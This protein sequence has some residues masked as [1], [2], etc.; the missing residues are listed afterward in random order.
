M[1]SIT[2]NIEVQDFLK[3]INNNKEKIKNKHNGLWIKEGILSI[4]HEKYF[5]L[6]EKYDNKE[7]RKVFEN[8][9]IYVEDAI[10]ALHETYTVDKFNLLVKPIVFIDENIFS[11][12][13]NEKFIEENKEQIKYLKKY[14]SYIK[15]ILESSEI[16]KI[17]DFFQSKSKKKLID[18]VNVLINS[19]DFQSKTMLELLDNNNNIQNYVSIG[20]YL[21]DKHI[22]NIHQIEN[23]NKVYQC[24]KNDS[25]FTNKWFPKY[26]EILVPKIKNQE[27][28]EDLLYTLFLGFRN[29][30]KA[31]LNIS[32]DIFLKNENF[33]FSIL[34]FDNQDIYSV[35]YER[36]IFN[37]E[38]LLKTK[39]LDEILKKDITIIL[40][41]LHPSFLEKYYSYPLS[42]DSSE[43][44]DSITNSIIDGY[45]Y[46]DLLQRA[47]KDILHNIDENI[48]NVVNEFI[49]DVKNERDNT[50]T[51]LIFY[52]GQILEKKTPLLKLVVDKN[53]VLNSISNIKTSNV[54]KK[55]L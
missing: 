29:N 2:E 35:G 6:L 39:N 23:F 38:L 46:V 44:L 20:H 16:N 24:I 11:Y 47:K 7:L 17:K 18:A 51:M 32:H 10:F 37:A 43:K 30:S 34:K 21:Y 53:N 45:K 8:L 28:F 31:F 36:A 49:I 27:D 12:K 5:M 22:V 4:L 1:N 54:V 25:L 52:I 9:P 15:L 13:H 40:N 48:I 3:F 33:L 14:L 50:N 41:I 19:K 26:L 42:Y 55:K